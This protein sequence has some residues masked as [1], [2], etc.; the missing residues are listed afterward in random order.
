MMMDPTVAMLN[1][2]PKFVTPIYLE[3]H[4]ETDEVFVLLDDAAT[5]VIGNRFEN[6]HKREVFRWPEETEK[7]VRS[8]SGC[9]TSQ[10]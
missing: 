10:N 3:R 2:G 7:A 1:H 4:L 9:Q 8:K 5:L 6:C